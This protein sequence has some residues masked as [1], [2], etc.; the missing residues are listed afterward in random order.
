MVDP[1][2]PYFSSAQ[3]LLFN[4]Q[5]TVL[6]TCPCGQ[7]GTY[8]VPDGVTN[9]GNDAF[10]HCINL[11]SITMPDG[12]ATIGSQAFGEC[13]SL[14]NVTLPSHLNTIESGLFDV[15]HSLTGIIIPDSVTNI[16]DSAFFGCN[17]LSNVIIPNPVVNIGNEAFTD[18]SGLTRAMIGGS[19][20]NIESDAFLGCTSLIGVYFLSNAPSIGTSVFDGDTNAIVYYLPGTIGWGPTF[21]GLPAKLWNPQA[22]KAPSFGV[23]TNG[24]GFNITGSSNL[25]VVV[26]AC[27]NLAHP[28]W[29]PVATNILTG[30]ASCFCDP[31]WTNCPGQFYRFR[32]P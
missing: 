21:G 31:Q 3:G 15:C 1:T 29:V 5:Q 30:G 9:I 24:F 13:Y 6:L 12:V 4:K 11:T 16:G 28:R 18:C 2:N 22:A 14:T 27:T 19:V 23:R 10:L 17:G 26:E 20:S 7:T 32:S 25:V 8:T